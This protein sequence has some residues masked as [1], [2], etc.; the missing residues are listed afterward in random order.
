MIPF[1]PTDAF[2]PVDCAEFGA[3]A[4]IAPEDAV[5]GDVTVPL[6]HADPRGP[7][8][9]L[10]VAVVKRGGAGGGEAGDAS[11]T[12][13]STVAQVAP[14][15]AA[16]PLILLQGGPGGSTID[17]FLDLALAPETGR[18]WRA[19]GGSGISCCSTSAGRATAGRP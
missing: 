11:G 7:T 1:A 4:D 12:A 18:A 5:C 10:A 8:I 17:A 3:A 14:A 6:W 9:T 2:A 15:A 19:S 16:A 13:K